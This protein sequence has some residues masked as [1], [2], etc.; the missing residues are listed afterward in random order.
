MKEQ[1]AF[2]RGLE[3]IMEGYWM[4]YEQRDIDKIFSYHP[5]DREI[6]M[7]G[8]GKHEVYTTL[9]E[10][11]IGLERDFA[12]SDKVEL[13]IENFIAESSGKVAWVSLNLVAKVTIKGKVHDLVTRYTAVLE[14][15]D[16][17]WYIMQSHLSFPS[18]EQKEGESFPVK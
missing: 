8:T 17:K 10:Y 4:A 9:D 14:L 7:I 3:D 12:Q 5:K 6:V 16:G 1:H 2:H 13:E 15:I 11:R 18:E